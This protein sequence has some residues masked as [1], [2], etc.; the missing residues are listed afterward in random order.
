MSVSN[1]A[2]TPPVAFPVEPF[3]SPVSRSKIKMSFAPALSQMIRDARA[4]NA[5]ADDNDFCVFHKR[6]SHEQTRKT[7]KIQPK[8]LSCFFVFVRG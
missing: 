4:D 8:K 3:P 6:F 1:C 5:A 2:L 7:T